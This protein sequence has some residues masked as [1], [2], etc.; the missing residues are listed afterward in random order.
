MIVLAA[1]FILYA[2]IEKWLT[3]P[4]LGNLGAGT[5]LVL[6]AGVLNAGLG[7]T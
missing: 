7:G 3:G 1:I 6:A 4:R 5:I 2:A